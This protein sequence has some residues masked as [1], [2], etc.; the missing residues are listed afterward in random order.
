MK[1]LIFA[2]LTI[3]QTENKNNQIKTSHRFKLKK[4]TE[5]CFIIKQSLNYKF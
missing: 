1:T 5:N 3:Y 4:K 2:I